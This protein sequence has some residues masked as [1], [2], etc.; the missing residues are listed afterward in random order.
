MRR[1]LHQIF[2]EKTLQKIVC[3][4]FEEQLTAVDNAVA[5]EVETFGE[6][7]IL[8]ATFSGHAIVINESGN[9]LSAKYTYSN[10]K[11]R[12]YKTESLDV[13]VLSS[14]SASKDAVDSFLRG[15]SISENLRS[16]VK[17]SLVS[18]ESALEEVR[19]ILEG[20]FAKGKTWKKFIEENRAKMAQFAFDPE[21]G[22]PKIEV[23]SA[24]EDLY[25]DE[26]EESELEG[27]RGDVVSSL[28]KIEERIVGLQ[29]VTSEAYEKYIAE[30]G[31]NHER[32]DDQI[33]TQFESF[34]DDYL[35]YIDEVNDFISANINTSKTSCV[36][37]L[38]LV[39]DETVKQV[40]E[41][42]LGSR[43]IRKISTSFFGA[44]E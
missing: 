21:Y 43:L 8:F 19:N 13:P 26:I 25:G 38:A 41:L 12:F 7:A 39:H 33:L 16:L 37:C 35:N 30:T 32:E 6:N 1:S 14:D 4:S 40:E 9:F 42:E 15:D 5:D 18:G 22:S 44:D 27:R 24:F 28:A 3:G 23:Q 31:D 29:N 34:A 10:G 2:E 17:T 11:V 36:A 20:I